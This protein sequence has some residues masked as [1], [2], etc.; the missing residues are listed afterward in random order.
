MLTE[1]IPIVAPVRTRLVE[2][3]R[4]NGDSR[5]LRTGACTPDCSEVVQDFP[6]IIKVDGQAAHSMNANRRSSPGAMFNASRAASIGMVPDP[7]NGSTSGEVRSHA[8][9]SSS[10]APRLSRSGA[11][12]VASR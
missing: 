12:A 1:Q 3:G 2:F 6:W 10:P 11:L 8:A 7:Q 4:G 9:A 5:A